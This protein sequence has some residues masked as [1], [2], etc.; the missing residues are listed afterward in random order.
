MREWRSEEVEELMIDSHIEH[1]ERVEIL[2][3]LP[4]LHG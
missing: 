4:V 1:V 2:H 3:D